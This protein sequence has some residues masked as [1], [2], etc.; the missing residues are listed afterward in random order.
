MTKKS[1]VYGISGASLAKYAKEM[2]KPVKKR[3]KYLTCD[4]C[5]KAKKSVK[6]VFDPYQEEIH[7]RKVKTNLCDECH[8]LSMDEI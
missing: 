1:T 4:D 6:E 8:Q 5:G 2:D 7:G 3:K